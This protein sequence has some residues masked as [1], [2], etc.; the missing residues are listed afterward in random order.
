MHEV[1]SFT[2]NIGAYVYIGVG[3]GLPLLTDGKQGK[4]HSLRSADSLF[5]TVILTEGLKYLIQEKRPDSNAHDSFPS[6]HAS[7]AFAIATMQ[8]QF[9]P[10]Q[11][12]YWFAGATLI[13]ISRFGLHRHTVGDVLAGAALG[14][15]TSRLELSR[16]TK[17]F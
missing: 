6:E 14:Y 1:Y 10:R 9:H 8:S 3:V 2:S 11:A 16:F 5:S 15:G 17:T 7:A 13:G 12:P 4:A